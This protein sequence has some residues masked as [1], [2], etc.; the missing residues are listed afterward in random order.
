VVVTGDATSEE[1]AQLLRKR[2]LQLGVPH[3]HVQ[4][5]TQ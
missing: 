1:H 3:A 4:E 5:F 2:A